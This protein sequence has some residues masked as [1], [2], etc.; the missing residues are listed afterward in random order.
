MKVRTGLLG[1]AVAA[2]CAEDLGERFD[3]DG[4]A[5]YVNFEGPICSAT[6]PYLERRL[7]WLETELD[8]PRGDE[9]IVYRWFPDGNPEDLCHGA[10]CTVGSTIYGQ[11]YSVSHE[12]VHAHLFQLGE[13]RP[14]LAEGMATMLEDQNNPTASEARQSPSVLMW[15]EDSWHVN[16]W[17]AAR[18]TAYLR[19]RFGM[20]RLLEYYAAS[21][22]TGPEEAID[23][24]ED[25]FEVD[26]WTL[27]AQYAEY[28]GP[29]VVGA[30]ACDGPVVAWQGEEWSHAFATVCDDPAAMGPHGSAVDAAPP[31]RRMLWTDA[32]MDAPA[33]L[34][35]LAVDAPADGHTFVDVVDC[36]RA[37]GVYLSPVYAPQGTWTRPVA[38]K[39]LLRVYAP[40]DEEVPV[41]VRVRRGDAGTP[42]AARMAPLSARLQKPLPCQHYHP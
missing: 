31:R 41:T 39:V 20:A 7:R 27:S 40:I 2:G 10:D 37:D 14:W 8:L 15:A 28:E 38:G 32:V 1:L 5:V 4:F 24:F 21:S 33:G 13:P 12:M 36:A 42:E 29:D 30:L 16:Y 11:L 34:L 18:F 22:G 23:T 9:P 17:D 35:T 3:R 19:N 26:F 25:V 6:F